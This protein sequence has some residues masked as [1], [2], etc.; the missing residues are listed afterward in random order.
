MPERYNLSLLG[1]RG[2]G[3]RTIA[4]ALAALYGWKI[5]DPVAIV[6]K[7][8]EKQKKFE[9]HVPSNWDPKSNSIHFSESEFK[10]L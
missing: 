3:K 2:C 8:L 7:T 6:A 1:P 5:I 10:E 4:T 9:K